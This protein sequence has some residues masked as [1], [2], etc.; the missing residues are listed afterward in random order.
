MGLHV[1]SAEPAVLRERMRDAR[2]RFGG[3]A[4]F[5]YLYLWDSRNT[6]IDVQSEERSRER[7]ALREALLPLDER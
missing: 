5:G 4:L 2:E 3:Y 1:T 7:A 6:V